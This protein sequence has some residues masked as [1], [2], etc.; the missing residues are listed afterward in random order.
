[1]CYNLINITQK[2]LDKK[3]RSQFEQA[4][5]HYVQ[6]L[7]ARDYHSAE[8]AKKR[9]AVFDSD[10]VNLRRLLAIKDSKQSSL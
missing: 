8:E 5:Y 6:L 9:Q 10:M 2:H 3:R 4:L 7:L 1:M